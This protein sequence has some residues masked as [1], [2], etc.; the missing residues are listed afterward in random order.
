MV[1][2]PEKLEK[3]DTHMDYSEKTENGRK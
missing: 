2:N 1:R 3:W